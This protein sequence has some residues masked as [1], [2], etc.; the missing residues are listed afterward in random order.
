[1]FGLIAVIESDNAEF[2]E[3]KDCVMYLVENKTKEPY[4]TWKLAVLKRINLFNL[5]ENDNLFLTANELCWKLSCKGFTI[6][7][8]QVCDDFTDS[9]LQ[10][11]FTVNKS[12]PLVAF[13]TLFGFLL[14][15]FLGIMLYFFRTK[16]K[17]MFT[18]F[19]KNKPN[20]ISQPVYKKVDE[21][22]SFFNNIYKED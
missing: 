18:V 13:I 14:L 12:Q 17:K 10:H 21:W 6:T 22:D 2:D 11:N 3:M 1:M 8:E 16:L 7:P 19:N 5:Q 4:N 9:M 20:K 15:I